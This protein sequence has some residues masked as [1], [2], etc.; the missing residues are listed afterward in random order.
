MLAVNMTK[1]EKG[2]TIKNIETETSKA[3]PKANRLLEQAIDSYKL[4]PTI[5]TMDAVVKLIKQCRFVIAVDNNPVI[6]MD[7]VVQ[8]KMFALSY[9]DK[10]VSLVVFTNEDTAI[11]HAPGLTILAADTDHILKKCIENYDGGIIICSSKNSIKFPVEK[12]ESLI[13]N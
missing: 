1:Q 9:P 8:T 7:G 11:K 3:L 4:E 10:T 13:L 12:I 2:F 6:K 5:D